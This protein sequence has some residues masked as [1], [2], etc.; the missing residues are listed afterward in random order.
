MHGAGFGWRVPLETAAMELAQA[1]ETAGE[2]WLTR[3]E[4][5]QADYRYALLTTH[6]QCAVQERLKDVHRLGLVADDGLL[7][8]IGRME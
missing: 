3:E 2:R 8:H 7:E 4:L 6:D 5:L 1:F